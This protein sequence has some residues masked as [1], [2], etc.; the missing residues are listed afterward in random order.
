MSR[1][2]RTPISIP[3]GVTV[4]ISGREAVVHGPKGELKAV[5]PAGIKV[6]VVDNEVKV[7]RTNDLKQT[8][9][10]HGLLRSLINNHIIGVTEGYT[11]T[12]KLVGTG[13]RA[14]AKGAGIS[15][16][17]GLSHQVDVQPV[18]EVTFKV[19]GTDTIHIEGIDKQ[20]VG[21]VAADIRKLR[22]PEPYK[23]KGIRYEDEIVRTKPGKTAA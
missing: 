23:G 2:G 10:F 6:D 12:L 22:P 13:Y 21:Q 4:T 8:R 5:V 15:L 17:L 1:I 18:P 9:A 14:Q 20:T 16:S 7:E 19:E 11:K 3:S